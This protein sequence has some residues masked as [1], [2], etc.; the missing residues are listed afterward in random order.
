MEIMNT[1]PLIHKVAHTPNRH[2]NVGFNQEPKFTQVSVS[3][4]HT[5]NK[6]VH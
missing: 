2:M 6:Q 5:T 3:H 1:G 4:L